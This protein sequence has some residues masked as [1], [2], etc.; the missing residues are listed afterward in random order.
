MVVRKVKTDYEELLGSGT[1]DEGE[2]EVRLSFAEWLS[3]RIGDTFRRNNDYRR[4][5]ITPP[6]PPPTRNRNFR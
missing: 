3:Q 6:P 4:K 5:Y 2:E 1:Q